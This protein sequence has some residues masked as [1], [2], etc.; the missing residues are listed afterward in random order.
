MRWLCAVV[1]LFFVTVGDVAAQEVSAAVSGGVSSLS[2]GFPARAPEPLPQ[3]IRDDAVDDAVKGTWELGLGY[4]LVG[5]RSTP[6]NST[7]SGLDSTVSYYFRDHF[8]VEGRLSSSWETHSSNDADAKQVFYGAGIKFSWGNRKLQ[9]FVHAFLGGVHMFPQT[10]FGNNGLGIE[11]GGGVQ[12]RLMQRLWLK[13]EGDYVRSQ[14]Y[15]SG[16]NNF[17]A[18][19]GVNY[20]F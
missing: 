14:L 6:F 13:F 3:A 9:P 12:K 5:F 7:L 8:A 18:V 17:Q 15:S 16:Q 1:F 11:L 19:V 10:A 20:R 2:A 4:A